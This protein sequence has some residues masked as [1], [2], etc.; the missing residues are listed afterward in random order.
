MKEEM[1]PIVTDLKHKVAR[2]D[3][4]HHEINTLKK[5]APAWYNKIVPLILLCIE[6]S[7]IY[8]YHSIHVILLLLGC[9]LVFGGWFLVFKVIVGDVILSKLNSAEVSKKKA[10]YDGLLTDAEQ[11]NY[12]PSRYFSRENLAYIEE[13]IR[14]NRVDSI[15]E[16]LQ[17]LDAKL[18]NEEMTNKVAELAEEQEVTNAQLRKA[19]SNLKELRNQAYYDNK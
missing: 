13:L 10:E 15:K 14:Y 9:L 1:L 3:E 11:N 5:T 8:K 6:G 19:N 7:F 4:L 16:A 17:L 18:H 12:I 2:L